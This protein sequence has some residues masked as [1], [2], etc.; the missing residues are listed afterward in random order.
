MKPRFK[1]V[2]INRLKLHM[3]RLNSYLHKI[4]LHV[5]GL[6]D[7]CN[8]PETVEHFILKCKKHSDLRE[9]LDNQAKLAS[10][11]VLDIVCCLSNKELIDI[12]YKYVTEHDVQ[13]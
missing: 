8:V 13:L 10:I 11:E 9:A 4:G 6:C 3:C 2:I 1:E 7:L 12:I 5:S